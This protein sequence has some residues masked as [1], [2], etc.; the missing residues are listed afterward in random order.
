MFDV[1]DGLLMRPHA[2]V[3]RRYQQDWRIGGEQTGGEEIIRPTRRRAREKVGSRRRH[4]NEIGAASQRD[5]IEG[6]PF[7]HEFGVHRAPRERLERD[8]ADEL[9]R[10][11]REHYVN[12]RAALREQ[13]R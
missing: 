1:G 6:V 5:V 3:H 10:R 2:I 12:F 13:P 11:T 8:G 7:G 9:P 4:H